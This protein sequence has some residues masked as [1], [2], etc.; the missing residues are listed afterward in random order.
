MARIKASDYRKAQEAEVEFAPGKTV[1]VKRRDLVTLFV[2]GKLPLTMVG[3]MRKMLAT[4][5]DVMD[6]PEK[7]A[8]YIQQ[9]RSD[10]LEMMRKF[11]VACVADPVLVMEEDDDPDHL[12]VHVF[13]IHELLAIWKGTFE[14]MGI[15]ANSEAA[16]V[17]ARFRRAVGALKDRADV[18]T[19]SRAST[20]KQLVPPAAKGGA[21][22]GRRLKAVKRG[23]RAARG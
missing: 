20:T 16:S 1:L 19:A 21:G 12:D 9:D 6:D 10:L 3:E 13:E 22:K 2:E 5:M 18:P 23:G 11:V 7:L 14:L 15:D 4:A 17:A 8:E